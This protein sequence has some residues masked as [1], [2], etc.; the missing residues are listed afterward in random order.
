[1]RRMDHQRKMYHNYYCDGKWGDSRNYDLCVNSSALG[2]DGSV[3]LLF[4]FLQLNGQ[5]NA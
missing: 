1:M 4:Q 5:H 3:E 2:V